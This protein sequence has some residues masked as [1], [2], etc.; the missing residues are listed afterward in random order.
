MAGSGSSSTFG[1]LDFVRV[2]HQWRLFWQRLRDMEELGSQH[3]V[4]MAAVLHP[5]YFARQSPQNTK[6]EKKKKKKKKDLTS[7]ST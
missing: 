6:G 3:H 2:G 1:Q 5:A 7:K 4:L